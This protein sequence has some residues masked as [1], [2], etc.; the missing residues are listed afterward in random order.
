MQAH[1]IRW[2][3]GRTALTLSGY[4][5]HNNAQCLL[6]LQMVD[7]AVRAFGPGFSNCKYGGLDGMR[8]CRQYDGR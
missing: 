8:R 1:I 5:V 7:G 2:G 6:W 4:A 3:N